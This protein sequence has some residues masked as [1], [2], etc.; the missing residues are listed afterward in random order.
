MN[1]YTIQKSSPTSTS[2]FFNGMILGIVRVLA[3]TTYGYTT[4]YFCPYNL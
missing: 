3:F 1:I 2:I 4:K